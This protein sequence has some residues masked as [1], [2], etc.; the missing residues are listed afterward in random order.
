MSG[1]CSISA[2]VISEM[3][4]L[5]SSIPLKKIFVSDFL[6]GFFSSKSAEITEVSRYL[7]SFFHRIIFCTW[8]LTFLHFDYEEKEVP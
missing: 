8:Y 7:N 5:N 1:V 6:S 2:T 4:G 3:Y